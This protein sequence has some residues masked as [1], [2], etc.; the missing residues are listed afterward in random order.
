MGSK[1]QYDSR[2]VDFA[3][4]YFRPSI[5]LRRTEA[6]VNR[7]HEKAAAGL[8]QRRLYAYSRDVMTSAIESSIPARG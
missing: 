4:D 2:V 6:S 1:A 7:G 3:R 8:R 5:M